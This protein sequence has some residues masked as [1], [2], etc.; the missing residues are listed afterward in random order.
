MEGDTWLV[1]SPVTLEN[2]IHQIRK[3]FDKNGFV[4]VK[5]ESNKK[6]SLS[7]NNSLHLYCAWLATALNDGGLD[8][9]KVLDTAAEIPWTGTSVKEQLWRPVQKAMTGKASTKDQNKAEFVD[10]YEVLNR[11]IAAKFGVSVEWPSS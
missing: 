6:R 3:E 2:C 11:H 8:M 4:H 5:T 9:M 7:Q 1:N 10:I